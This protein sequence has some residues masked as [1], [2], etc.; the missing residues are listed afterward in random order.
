MRLDPQLIYMNITV[1]NAASA[2]NGLYRNVYHLTR[3]EKASSVDKS[4]SSISD[5]KGGQI[6]L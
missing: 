1:N 6:S 2:F 5:S 3:L 4:E